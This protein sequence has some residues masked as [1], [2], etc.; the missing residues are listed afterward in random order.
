MI[1]IAVVGTMVFG[2]FYLFLVVAY[3]LIFV[4]SDYGVDAWVQRHPFKDD[5]PG[6]RR[7]W[8]QSDRGPKGHLEWHH[9]SDQFQREM[10]GEWEASNAKLL[11]ELAQ[12]YHRRCDAF[13][14]EVCGN[15]EGRPTNP[16]QWRRI[17]EHARG[18]ECELWDRA[19]AMGVVIPL[20]QLRKE[21]Q[22]CAK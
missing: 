20:D 3:H 5:C 7:W 9:S 12:E 4:V 6:K 8:W 21:I 2:W 15:E 13:D 22:R 10:L 1:V 16:D 18:V 11:W 14:V 17:L 19:E